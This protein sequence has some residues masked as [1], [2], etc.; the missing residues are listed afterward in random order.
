MAAKGDTFV[1]FAMLYADEEPNSSVEIC[2][3]VA[4]KFRYQGM[5]TEIWN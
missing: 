3:N 1:G 5:S 2:L 4:P